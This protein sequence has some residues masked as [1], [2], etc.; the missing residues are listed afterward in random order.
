M[1]VS[2][3]KG[4]LG[5][6][7]FQYAIGRALSIKH[8]KKIYLDVS[9]FEH[10]NHRVIRTYDLSSFNINAT[11]FISKD[12]LPR[13]FFQRLFNKEIDFNV[14]VEK[15][16]EYDLE[17]TKVNSPIHLDGY[18]QSYKYFEEISSYLYK[19]ITLNKPL[20]DEAS[21]FYNQMLGRENVAVHFRRGDYFTDSTTNTIHGVCADEYYFAALN[22]LKNYNDNLQVF[23]FSDDIEFLKNKL[24]DYKEY[25]FVDKLTNHIEEFEL[26][27]RC[28]HFVI[29][30]STFSWW[31]AWLS[32]SS[33]KKVIAPKL[34]FKDETLQNKSNDLI[35]VDWIRI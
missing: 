5:N 15:G 28:N 18:W 20:S 27:K 9:D 16:F 22:Y 29:S 30:N 13:T 17:I 12:E 25:I 23:I 2:K 26:M 32:R 3:L 11:T 6:Q 21:L 1:I 34:W 8:K 24:I 14:V 4:G 33:N 7:L 31:A 35:P 10:Q 19:E